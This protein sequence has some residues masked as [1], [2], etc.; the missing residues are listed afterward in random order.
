LRVIINKYIDELPRVVDMSADGCSLAVGKDSNEPVYFSIIRDCKDRNSENC[1]RSEHKYSV[2][3]F[4][5]FWIWKVTCK[6]GESYNES[7]FYKQSKMSTDVVEKVSLT[8]LWNRGRLTRLYAYGCLQRDVNFVGS[9]RQTSI[10]SHICTHTVGLKFV[11][12]A[13]NDRVQ[14]RTSPCAVNICYTARLKGIIKEEVLQKIIRT[15]VGSCGSEIHIDTAMGVVQI[16]GNNNSFRQITCKAFVSK[17]QADSV[18]EYICDMVCVHVSVCTAVSW[19]RLSICELTPRRVLVQ[20]GLEYGSPLVMHMLVLYGTVGCKLDISRDGYIVD[21]MAMHFPD[22]KY[23]A[24]IEEH[25]IH[26]LF[27]WDC[28]LSTATDKTPT[29]KAEILDFLGYTELTVSIT[30]LGTCIYRI[31]SKI[32]SDSDNI[33]EL[34]RNVVYTNETEMFIIRACCQIHD[35]ISGF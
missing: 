33:D 19:W 13:K 28:I 4:R 22:C 27:K 35:T 12:D 18:I 29:L 10:V 2:W 15:D 14:E 21:K 9:M 11:E 26:A 25:N 32:K 23:V 5:K 3:N 31:G 17:K 6:Y 24:P 7:S 8:S 30:R 34:K 1:L 16:F 20:M